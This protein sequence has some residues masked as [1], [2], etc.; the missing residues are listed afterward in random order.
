MYLEAE[1]IVMVGLLCMVSIVAIVLKTLR[2]KIFT[3]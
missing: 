3:V 2:R 1:F